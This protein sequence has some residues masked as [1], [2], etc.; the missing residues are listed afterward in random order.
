[1]DFAIVLIFIALILAAI[2]LYQVSGL[3]RYEEEIGMMKDAD[4]GNRSD[5]NHS[6]RERHEKENVEENEIEEK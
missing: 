1:M 4:R 6:E 2:C 3:K 5:E